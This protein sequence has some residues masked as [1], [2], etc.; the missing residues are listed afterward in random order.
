MFSGQ[1]LSLA[2]Q[3]A[4]LSKKGFAEA[5]GAHPRTIMRWE[6]DDRQPG[7]EELENL[8]K[9]LGFPVEFFDG[10]EIDVADANAAS[11]RSM[12]SMTA[13]ERDGALASGSLGFL[14]FDW[15]ETQ[16]NLPDPDLEDLRYETPE[17]AARALREAW[18]IGERPISNMIGLLEAKGV[19]ICSLA[20]EVRSVDAFS[21]WRRNKPYV[22]LNSFKSSEHQ[23]FDA[24]HELGHLVLHRHGAPRGR[25]AEDE[26]NRFAS[27][28]LMPAADVR[29]H[30]PIVYGLS[31]LVRAKRRWK[32][33]VAALNYRVHRLRLT[34]EWEYRGLCIEI[35]KAGY[36][37]KEPEGIERETSQV[38]AQVFEDLRARGMSKIELAQALAI[39]PNEID[40]LVFGLVS[41]L[42]LEGGASGTGQGIGRL[43]LVE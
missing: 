33:S 42:P 4:G 39:P 34:T 13:R 32:V 9:V 16:F 5:I 27:A 36:R 28:F 12:S 8:A 2:R 24:A 41:M 26:A 22:F 43:R 40:N 20:E 17:G 10:S 31:S 14:A 29:A 30:L 15:I 7:E 21:M 25:E 35:Q 11:F 6:A 3:R 23:R 18:L 38:W 37:T 19:R 1:R